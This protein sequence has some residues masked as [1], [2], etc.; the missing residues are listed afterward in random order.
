[1]NRVVP[2]LVVQGLIFLCWQAARA[3]VFVLRSGG[4]IT[5]ELVNR[6]ESPRQKYVIKTTGGQITLEP[7]QVAQVLTPSPAEVDYE[8]VRPSFA[9]TVQGQCQAAAWCMEHGLQSQRKLHLE[10]VIEL[11]PNHAEARRLLGFGLHEGKWLTRDELMKARGYVQYHGRWVTPQQVELAEDRDKTHKA[12]MI[13]MQKINLWRGWLWTDRDQ[14]A[15]QNLQAINDP[16][17]VK[18]LSAALQSDQR[19]KARTMYIDIL[20]RLNTPPAVIALAQ[21]SVYDPMEEIRLSC[22]DYLKQQKR[23]V[24]VAF[25]VHEIKNSK[26]NDI[27]NRAAVCLRYMNDPSA[28]LPLIDA[29]VTVHKKTIG[30][31]GGQGSIST[32]FGTGGTG[33]GGLSINAQPKVIKQSIPNQCVLD[34]L[35]ALSGGANFGYDPPAWKAWYARQKPHETIDARR[36][37]KA[38][39]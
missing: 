7:S 4:R 35:I 36:G 31:G 2:A 22:L 18:G 25:Y 11:D 34:A 15:R 21:T 23:P 27:I 29:L 6:E 20:G 32:T 8:K 3:E 38:D 10:R 14:V 30:G 12:E 13:W 24:V 39:P 37:T 9:D 33:G 28:I 1:V 5:G 16:L 17:A 19:F 26:D